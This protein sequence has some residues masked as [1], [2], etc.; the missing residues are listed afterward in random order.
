M[1]F[2][3][4]VADLSG[5]RGGQLFVEVDVMD[6]DAT[7][8]GQLAD[9]HNTLEPS[10]GVSK[11]EPGRPRIAS[12]SRV[13]CRLRTEPSMSDLECLLRQFADRVEIGDLLLSYFRALDNLDLEGV[14]NVYSDD[15][16][17]T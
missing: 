2:Q 9:L 10:S 6:L 12:V 3:E 4:G 5:L 14:L 7:D 17:L 1:R 13:R 8:R 15:A 11:R 16:R